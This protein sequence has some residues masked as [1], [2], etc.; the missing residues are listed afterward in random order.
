VPTIIFNY[1]SCLAGTLMTRA[2]REEGQT[3]A[4][5]GMLIAVIGVVVVVVAVLLGSSISK[6]FSSVSSHV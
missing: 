1:L 4:E 6:L 5:Y 2:R 3:M